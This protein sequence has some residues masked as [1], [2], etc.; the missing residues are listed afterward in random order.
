MPVFK[1]K[2]GGRSRNSCM[3]LLHQKLGHRFKYKTLKK[4]KPQKS[5]VERM[6]LES[7]RA[8][9]HRELDLEFKRFL[10]WYELHKSE[11]KYPLTMVESGVMTIDG[12]N[13]AIT[14]EYGI[15]LV[16]CVRWKDYYDEFTFAGAAINKTKH[17][18][19]DNGTLLEWR[20]TYFTEQALIEC[21][22][23]EPIR[24]WLNKK[25]D[26]FKWI[27]FCGDDDWCAASLVKELDPKANEHLP[28][29]IN[30]K[31]DGNETIIG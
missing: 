31:L 1:L 2:L 30:S 21:E 13:P 20:T 15:E 10:D 11:F 8:S 22:M 18:Y 12:V 24:D 7:S 25:L 16:V 23:F 29:F 17:G 19:E 14:V 27:A 26:T 28:I 3:H 6:R 5:Q 4:G 9:Y